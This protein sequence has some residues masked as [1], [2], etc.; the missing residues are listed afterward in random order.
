MYAIIN[1]HLLIPELKQHR[2]HW[3]NILLGN[4]ERV[5]FSA[6]L[7]PIARLSKTNCVLDR[8]TIYHIAHV[9]HLDVQSSI[10]LMKNL[11]KI[12]TDKCQIYL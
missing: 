7:R 5:F 11:K 12:I 9:F 8:M 3:V 6:P 2:L 4:C 1:Q 10:L